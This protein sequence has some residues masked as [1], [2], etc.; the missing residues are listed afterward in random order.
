MH[1]KN[2]CQK[3]L[4]S[5]LLGSILPSVKL[6]AHGFMHGQHLY[7]LTATELPNSPGQIPLP[8]LTPSTGGFGG[9]GDRLSPMGTQPDPLDPAAVP[10][11][12]GGGWSGRL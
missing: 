8:L 6:P 9:A 7:I 2:P 11:L 10:K 4:L 12:P 1:Q 3:Q 5:F